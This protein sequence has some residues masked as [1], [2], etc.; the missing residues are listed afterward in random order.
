[1]SIIDKIFGGQDESD[2]SMDASMEQKIDEQQ[3]QIQKLQQQLQNKEQQSDARTAQLEERLQ[4]RE[5]QLKELQQQLQDQQS[6]MQ[7]MQ[8]EQNQAA[9]STPPPD[10]EIL[11]GKPV[12]SAD[13]VKNFGKFKGWISEGSKVG[14]KCDHP[15]RDKKFEKV[16]WASSISELVMDANTLVDK[17][18]V[19]VKLNARGEKVNY[20]NMHRHK[21]VVQEKE[22]LEDQ[23]QRLSRENDELIKQNRKLERVNQKIMTTMSMDRLESNPPNGVDEMQLAEMSE[24]EKQM[25]QRTDSLVRQ[26]MH[27]RNRTDEIIDQYEETLDDHVSRPDASDMEQSV[28]DVGKILQGIF[29]QL[30][31]SFDELDPETK[32]DLMEEMTGQDGQGSIQIE[33]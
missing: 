5:N 7:Q 15:K 1:M 18:V 29:R 13:G 24:R 6:R 8:E 32:R 23:K 20:V 17:D 25:K 11:D 31:M 19:I 22:K 14:I 12:V 9:T 4:E 10:S 28:Q 30:D 2:L 26:N 27:N 33:E 3:E 16:G 21:E